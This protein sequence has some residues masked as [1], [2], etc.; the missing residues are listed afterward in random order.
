MWRNRDES[1][2]KHGSLENQGTEQQAHDVFSRGT[3]KN[4]LQP[5]TMVSTISCQG[6]HTTYGALRTFTAACELTV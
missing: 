4:G 3:Q 5:K 1:T 2:E 6:T